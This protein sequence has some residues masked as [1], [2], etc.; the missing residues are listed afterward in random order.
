MQHGRHEAGHVGQP[1]RRSGF[2][3]D[4]ATE[5]RTLV[6]PRVLGLLIGVLV[7]QIAFIF[8]YVAAFHAP[9]PTSIPVAVVAG[10][11]TQQV[12]GKLNA[13][14]GSPLKASGAADEATA[15]RQVTGGDKSAALVMNPRG[16]TDA[17]YVAGGGG[18]AV[19]SAVEQVTGQ[20]EASQ[21]RT[22]RTVD[23]VPVQKEDGRGL[24]GFYLV[25]GWIVGGY[26]VTAA[27]GFLASARPANVA[28]ATG[29]ILALVPYAVLSGLL[30]AIVVDP[31]L[32][33][34]TGHF[35]ALWGLGTL[36]V[37]SSA[38]M[39]IGMQALLGVVG[40]GV[41]ILIFV[42]LGNPSAGGPYQ[43]DLLPGFWRVIGPLIPNGAGTSAVRDIVYF[44]GNH[45]GG[46]IAV[47]VAYI[48]IGAAIALGATAF[49]SRRAASQ[50][51]DPA[52]APAPSH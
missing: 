41:T 38:V 47:I 9:K 51:A 10:P 21:Q 49:F 30:G 20:V 48:V 45:L 12:V 34:L 27:I 46:P 2:G 13:I 31:M 39:T 52:P 4:F 25:I 17:L 23:L 7:L 44:G 14:D 15:K 11:Q 37:L 24:T 6:S 22:A 26:L 33:A 29:R 32:G 16:T 5:L 42:V 8:S 50:A 35:M 1:P 19:V 36:L 40:I 18:P 28:A 43:Y 3:T